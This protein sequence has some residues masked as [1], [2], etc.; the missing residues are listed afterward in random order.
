MSTNNYCIIA[1]LAQIGRARRIQ[2]WLLISL[3]DKKTQIDQRSTY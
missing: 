2:Y 3:H 1:A